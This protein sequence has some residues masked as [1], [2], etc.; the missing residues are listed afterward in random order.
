MVIKSL[1]DKPLKLLFLVYTNYFILSI[2]LI[3]NEFILMQNE[4]ALMQNEF[5]LMQ[6]RFA[7][8]QNGLYRCKMKLH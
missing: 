3:Q 8:I 6:N 7:L 5:A 4:I 1:N 2:A